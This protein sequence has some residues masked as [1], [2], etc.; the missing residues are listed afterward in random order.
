MDAIFVELPAFERHRETYLSD[1]A[2]REL[3]DY[4]LEQPFCGDLIKGT[5]G[6]RK[7]RFS[8]KRRQKGTR[9]GIRV[10]YYFWVGGSRFW[11]FT[12][13]SKDDIEDLTEKQKVLLRGVLEDMLK[14]GEH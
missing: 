2:F 4:L 14:E 8:D 5:G 12:L 11:L 10:I 6:L 9:S 13:Y 1:D 7:V 3:Q